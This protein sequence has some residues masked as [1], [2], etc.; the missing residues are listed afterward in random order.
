MCG[1]WKLLTL[2]KIDVSETIQSKI[3]SME[4]YSSQLEIVDGI[5]GYMSGLSKVRGYSI[6][7]T[8]GEA[9]KRLSINPAEVA[10]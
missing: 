10:F 5:F 6:G 8:A 7:V 9:F 4:V 1:E 2:I 3:K